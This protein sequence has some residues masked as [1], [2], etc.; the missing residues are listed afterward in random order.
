MT[1]G[2]LA[3]R[4]DIF[5]IIIDIEGRLG[6]VLHPPD[7]NGGDLDRVAALVVDLEPLPVER[8][9]PQGHLVPGRGLGGAAAPARLPCPLRR[10]QLAF[11]LRHL[12]GELALAIAVG[13]KRVAPPEATGPNRAFVFSEQDQD[14]RLVG[15]QTEQP[16]GEDDACDF[17][18]YS[19]H[20]ESP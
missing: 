5:L 11:H 1:Q 18:Q 6:G 9:R 10:S 7:D 20:K 14:S 19:Q 13:V 4:L 17:H 3:L 15:L 12:D 8:A 2:R 16:H